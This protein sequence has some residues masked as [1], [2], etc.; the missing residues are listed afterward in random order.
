MFDLR[1]LQDSGI[2]TWED[3]ELAAVEQLA[4]KL[5]DHPLRPPD[6]SDPSKD[7]QDMDSGIKLPPYHCAF[8]GCP[9]VCSTERDLRAHVLATHLKNEDLPVFMWEISDLRYCDPRGL[10][11]D[12]LKFDYYVRAVQHLSLIHI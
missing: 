6:P 1:V 12:A 11:A 3:R 5:R 8:T 4:Q 7:F 10:P 9:Y 2:T